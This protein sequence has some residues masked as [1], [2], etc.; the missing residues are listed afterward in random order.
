MAVVIAVLAELG[1]HERGPFTWTID[2]RIYDLRK[3]SPKLIEQLAIQHA[4]EA[5]WKKAAKGRK[6]LDGLQGSVDWTVPRKML[7]NLDPEKA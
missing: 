1:W 2:G 6:D 4:T 5:V 7:N 3:D